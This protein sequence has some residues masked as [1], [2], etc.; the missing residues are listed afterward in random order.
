RL[1]MNE[2]EYEQTLRTYIGLEEKLLSLATYIP[3]ESDLSAPNYQFGSPAAAEFGLDCC[4]WIETLMK[5]LLLL[6]ELN[7]YPNI[8]GL[9]R[10]KNPSIDSYRQ[11]FE[12]EYKLSGVG[13]PLKY[14][15]ERI[16]PFAPW[17]DSRNPEWFRTYSRFKHDRLELSG[18]W[19]MKHALEAFAGLSVI[20]LLLKSCLGIAGA[21]RSSQIFREVFY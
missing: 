18:R 1:P 11:V 17:A 19:T 16:L 12:R 4:T 13:W 2:A 5:R 10:N 20:F 9:R 6:P 15:E 7:G 8:A 21:A 3:L 14:S